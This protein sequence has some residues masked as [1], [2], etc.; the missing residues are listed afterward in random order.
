MF[1][2]NIYR[3]K[4][5]AS[6]FPLCGVSR[7][8]GLYFEIARYFVRQERSKP[9]T[10]IGT[11]AIVPVKN[12][13]MEVQQG[14]APSSRRHTPEEIEAS[15]ERLSLV[16][17]HPFIQFS[18]FVLLERRY[19][20]D[21]M[22]TAKKTQRRPGLRSVLTWSSDMEVPRAQLD[23]PTAEPRRHKKGPTDRA[24]YPRL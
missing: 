4:G 2:F 17:H 8:T 7:P 24:E 1:V 21:H 15:S 3:I 22:Q 14:E 11:S 6:L 12:L 10:S 13:P 19:D 23:L 9:S 18:V 16:P 5:S 20:I